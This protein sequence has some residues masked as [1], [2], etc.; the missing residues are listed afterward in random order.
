MV[1]G[2]VHM[3]D[4]PSGPHPIIPRTIRLAAIP[5]LLCWLGFTVF[6]SVAVP[7]LEAIGETRAVAVAPDDAQ[8]M[9]AMRR[10]GKVFNEFD[11]NSIAMVVLESDQPLGEKAHR[12]Y[13]HLVDT[14]VLDQSHIQHIQDFWRDPLTAAGAVS[15]DGKAAYV[16]L[17][18]AGN[19]GEALANESVEAVRKIVA[20]STPPE[21]IRTYVTGPAALFADQIAAGDRSMKLITGL[22]FAVITV[23]LL[24]VYRSIATT[25]LILP[26]VFIGLGATRGTIAFLGYH[27]MVGL[28]TFVVN[29]LTALAI[30]AG[31]DYA[32]F[33]VG[34]YQEARHIGQNREA[35]F[36][37]MYRGTANVILGS[38]LTIAGATYC[39]SFARLTLFHTMGPPLAIG[40]LVSVAAALILAPAI[41]AIAGRFGLLDP[42]RRLKT[43][44]WR[45][46]GTAVVRWPGPILA[47]SV[48]LAL[49]GLLALPGYRPGYNDRYY[50][51]AGTPVNRG[52][53][54]ADRHFGPARMNP[55]MLLVE[56]DQDMRNPA[57]MLVIDKIAKEVLHVS[58]VERVQAITRP[59]GVPLEHASIPFQ[60]SMMGATQT[61]S[62]PYMRERMADM[63]TMSD[64]MLV[65]I[66]SMEQML[67]LVQQ[68]NDVTHEMAATTR[69]IKAT[70][71]E[72]RDHLA[73]IDDFVRPLRSYFYW[74]HH[75][76]DIPLC[77]ATRSLFDTLDGVDTLTDQLR[78]LT[79]DMNK[80]EALTPQFLA[81][82][83]PMITTM[84]TMRTMMLTMRSTISGVQDQ[85]ADMQD[86]AT[87]MGQAFDTAKSGDSFYLPPEAFDNAEFQQG[88]KL[89]L[90]PNGKAVRFVISHESDPASTEGIDRIEAI[91]AATK[92]AIKATPLQG[93]KI[94]IGG[95]A[96]TYQ[97]IRDGTKY[98]IL[99]VGIAA[100]CLVFIVMLMITQSLIASLVIVGTVL[101]S[102][103]TAFG[104]SVLIWQH[105]VGLQV[106]WTIVA[107]SVIVLLAV[108]SDYNL[109]L[110]SRFKEEVGAGLKTGIIRAMA[111]TGAV[112]TSAGLVFAFTMA[113]M[114]VSELRVI[115]QV[116]TTIGLGLLF[117]TLVV[118]SFMTPSIA[119][120]LGRWFW[121]PN[122]IHSRPTVP[123]A[124]TRQG[125]RRIQPH[126]H[127]G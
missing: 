35:S 50:L 2:E 83:P 42:K 106:H 75:C 29:I 82:L 116:G 45:R 67:D 93:A 92:D 85:M 6:V 96:A 89:F 16:Q 1:P 90:S 63:L 61:M 127:R 4:T 95:T 39:L 72:L 105:F 30:A 104:L 22:T 80:M 73:D 27:G 120:L 41:I 56:S 98:D 88:M 51:R 123:E 28:S 32:I 5:I 34:R 38:G 71:S 125:A 119:A 11:S 31:T 13:D 53:A 55:E 10:A 36:Y 81:L 87:A 86:H 79:D 60:I 108:G 15:A 3:S 12:Y 115:G 21:G 109:L 110:V 40:M 113:S 7:P 118:R 126:L 14:L 49:V 9:R 84:K 76:F 111:G 122:M 66:N 46:V 48:A 52:Y 91:R 62:L 112:V 43:R 23:L 18:L 124:H 107:M 37:T 47:T 33:L 103:G 58:G 101:L 102:L 74:E 19:M 64:E 44:G 20:N 24:L 25:L 114:A 97:D 99:I 54:A 77:S 78:A 121:W 59:Q 65:A 68:L 69:E 57:G 26:M 70:T 8:S 17:Y 94:Y 100:V 117:D